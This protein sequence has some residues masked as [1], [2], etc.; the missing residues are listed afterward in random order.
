MEEIVELQHAICQ[1]EFATSSGYCRA[2][3]W[4]FAPDTKHME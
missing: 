1:I 3:R 4:P 2:G